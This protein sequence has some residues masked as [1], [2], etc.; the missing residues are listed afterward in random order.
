MTDEGNSC[1]PDLGLYQAKYWLRSLLRR[2]PKLGNLNP[3]HLSLWAA[4][5][6]LLAAYCLWQGFW[7]GF[8]FC[9]LAR[10]FLNTI[11]GLVAEDFG[12]ASLLG[13]YLNR[14][15][16]EFNDMLTVIAL[17]PWVGAD[18]LVLLLALVG[19][20]QIFGLLGLV[21]G[22]PIQSVGPCGQTD[23]LILFAVFALLAA[24]GLNLWLDLMPWLC[25]GCGL[26]IVLRI[27]RSLAYLQ[28][29][30]ED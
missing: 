16:G 24:F 4:V 9:I 5:P 13:A 28:A 29:Q 30:S 2:I 3:N 7:W 26:T 21:A 1:K 17:W 22:A 10:L 15:P 23:R 18:W 27:W 11:D 12:K 14:L 25:F 8:V 19:L 6:G 20:I